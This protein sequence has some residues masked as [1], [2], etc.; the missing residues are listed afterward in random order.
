MKR[1]EAMAYRWHALGLMVL[2][3]LLL[4]LM[5]QALLHLTSG[6]PWAPGH[7]LLPHPSPLALGAIL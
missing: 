6:Y 2:V 3:L 7:P 1:K 4:G 5:A